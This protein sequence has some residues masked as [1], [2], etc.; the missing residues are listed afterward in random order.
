MNCN[1]CGQQVREGD[2]FCPWCGSPTPASTVASSA[3]PTGDS[4]GA[5]Q[6]VRQLRA[7]LDA[8]T[9]EV[10]RISLRLG[11]LER[12]GGTEAA[13]R[14]AQ[15]P[16]PAPVAATP[17]PPASRP[18]GARPAPPPPAAEAAPVPAASR[19]AVIALDR[20]RRE[21]PVFAPPAQPAAAGGGGIGAP[22]LAAARLR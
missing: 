21:P 15:L 19:E 5:D 16:P 20:E 6:E 3:P 22:R 14:P 4:A 8:V 9:V 2:R 18:E 1:N 11:V 13:S 12:R 17:A 7:D 10:G